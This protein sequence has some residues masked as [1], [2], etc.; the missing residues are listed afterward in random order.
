MATELGVAYV[1]ILPSMDGFSKSLGP[2]FKKAEKAAEDSG[3]KAGGGFG[4]GLKAAGLL[5]AAAAGAA[6]GA[7]ASAAI[8]S[9]LDI[10]KGNDKLAAQLGL[11]AKESESAGKIAGSLY[12]GAYGESM[13]EVQGAVGAVMSS[14]EGMRTASSKDVEAT[15][16]KVLDMS[17]AFEIDV[18]RAAQVAGQMITSGL[19]DDPNEAIDLLVGN[20]QKV[21]T[22]LRE[23]LLDAVDEYG[24]FFA[25]LGIEG[26]DAMGMLARASED[27]MYGIDKT[28]DAIKEF[29]I[30]ATDMSKATR[31]AYENLGVDHD[32]MVEKLLAG[33]PAANEAMG[34]I[35][36][37]LMTTEDPAQRAADALAL[38]GTPLEDLSVTEIPN[39]LGMIDPMGD[40]FDTMAGK[41][42]EMGTTLNDNAGTK[43]EGFKRTIETNVVNFFGERV[44]PAIEDFWAKAQPVFQWVGDN[45]HIWGPF[46]AGVGLVAGAFVAWS[47]G[48]WA[49]AAALGVITSPIT[50]VVAGIG[51]LVGAVIWAYNNIGWFKD[52]VDTAFKFIGDVIKNVVSWFTGT[53]VPWFTKALDALGAAFNWLWTYIIKPVFDFIGWGVKAMWT[54][55]NGI[56]QVMIAGLKFALGPAFKWF[57]DYVKPIL[58]VVGQLI[59]NLWKK[60]VEPVFKWISDGVKALPAAF[61]IAKDGIGKAWDKIKGIARGPVEFVINRVINDGLIG[62]FNKIPGVNIKRIPLPP[63]FAHGGY[64]GDGGKYEPAGVVHKGE[65]VFTKEQ[66]ARIGRDRLAAMAAT[67]RHDGGGGGVAGAFMGNVNAIKQHGAYFLKAAASVGPWGF[68][69]AARMWDGAAGVRVRMGSGQHQGHVSSLERGGGILGYTTGTNIDM[70]PSWMARLGAAQRRTV[71]A[72]E[73]G[74]ALGLPHMGGNSIMQANLGNMAA[75]PTSQDVRMLQRLYPGGSGKAGSGVDNPFS[76]LVDGLMAAF[77][78][79][80][81]G[82][83]MFIDAAGGLAKSGIESVVKIVTD[84]QNGIKELAGN[85]WGNIK[86]FFGG[87]AAT[88]DLHDQGGW[89]NTGRSVIQNNTRKPE[90]I[91]NNQQWQDISKLALSEPRG[92]EVVINGNVGYDPAELVRVMERSERR[93][94]ISEGVLV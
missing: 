6:I 30:R 39:F 33:G 46:A 85:I 87:G 42:V 41:A 20:L 3:E 29:Q 61:E 32:V 58:D 69:A 77:K 49:V 73:I 17:A 81:P 25:N 11:T 86:S 70:S 38:F 60:H 57:Q 23:D 7:A 36:D 83:G 80:F 21:P 68:P 90:A 5:A 19:S 27:G 24:P 67:V 9:A 79:Q 4:E 16:A 89:L 59:G 47:V 88:A 62:T 92:R 51:L 22:A 12:A 55:V 28:G 53:A 26:A 15:T 10:E 63:G 56:F 43:I 34:Q 71:A 45:A 18:A 75:S 48:A 82:G 66:T 1:S 74:H 91:L 65:Y 72:H 84:I 40:S 50:L 44:I 54:V 2:G 94:R 93:Q 8:V 35:V 52:G 13:G 64:T 78:K 31:T 14:I 37:A 76:G